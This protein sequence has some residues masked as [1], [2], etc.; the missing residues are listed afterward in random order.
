MTF[1]FG[2][3]G[4]RHIF[5][6]FQLVNN[7]G[8][9]KNQLSMTLQ[10]ARYHDLNSENYNFTNHSSTIL[11]KYFVNTHMLNIHAEFLLHR[12][13]PNLVIEYDNLYCTK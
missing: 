4:K 13:C 9:Y 11:T 10:F 6:L 1:I 3:E 12:H 7:I 2:H 5:I 8:T